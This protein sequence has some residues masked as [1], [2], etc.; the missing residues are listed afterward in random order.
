MVATEVKDAAD[1]LQHADGLLAGI[2]TEH[3]DAPAG[4]LIG[5]TVARAAPPLVTG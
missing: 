4:R 2:P 5:E 1:A 3:A